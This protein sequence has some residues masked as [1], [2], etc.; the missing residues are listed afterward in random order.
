MNR[1]FETDP[2]NWRAVNDW[3]LQLLSLPDLANFRRLLPMEEDLQDKWEAAVMHPGKYVNILVGQERNNED[4][5][6]ESD[7]ENH[8]AVVCGIGSRRTTSW[9]TIRSRRTR[10][11]LH[12]GLMK[13]KT[14]E[15]SR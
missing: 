15:G 4:L 5:R 2:D 3:G 9:P 8:Y 14:S 10:V 7:K 11:G 12:Q 6:A 13:R 1:C